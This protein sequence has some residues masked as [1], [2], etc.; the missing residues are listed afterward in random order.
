MPT[1][2][3]GLIANIGFYLNLFGWGYIVVNLK[4]A[5]KPDA[6]PGSL[7]IVGAAFLICVGG[8]LTFFS[9]PVSLYL[10]PIIGLLGAAKYMVDEADLVK[11]L[12]KIPLL[13]WITFA[14]ILLRVGFSTSGALNAHDDY[15]GY[16]VLPQRILQT[17]TITP[18][19]FNERRMGV[20]GGAAYLQ[21][22]YLC[23]VPLDSITGLDKGVGIL[24]I[25]GALLSISPNILFNKKGAAIL[26]LCAI[27][28]FNS[29]NITFV[30]ISEAILLLL[31]SEILS[32]DDK[33]RSLFGIAILSASSIAIKNYMVVP[34]VALL[35]LFWLKSL[36]PERKSGSYK[37]VHCLLLTLVLLCPW[38]VLSL[39]SCGTLLFP[40]TGIGNHGSRYGLLEI[41]N[42]AQTPLAK[43][44][45]Y[46]WKF[47]KMPECLICCLGLFLLRHSGKD[48]EAMFA[49]LGIIALLST[50][51]LIVYKSMFLFRYAE[52]I[53]GVGAILTVLWCFKNGKLRSLAACIL[54]LFV[55]KSD[56]IPN[57]Y[58][59]WCD[60]DYRRDFFATMQSS[61]LKM[62]A[63]IPRDAPM[64]VF[65]SHPFLLDFSRN[66]V[67]V[68]DHYGGA[69]PPPGLPLN[70][71]QS[72]KKYLLTQGIQ[73]L[74]F[75]YRDHANYG[76]NN[77]SSRLVSDGSP[78]GER[79]KRLALLNFN[80]QD[81]ILRLS[82]T[83][84]IIFDDGST[85]VIHLAG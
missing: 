2:A 24:L 72:L 30:Y 1:L 18:D 27:L 5:S 56:R 45:E 44:V 63:S 64:A 26:L 57:N 15:H 65:V 79:V 51:W 61:M 52:S 11:V 55:L 50:A 58:K 14:V 70:K 41:A 46:F 42:N 71:E 60:L 34:V 82:K 25:A 19:I 47:L 69:S 12:K 43:H 22:L 6:H 74:V 36:Y 53:I 85:F 9:S 21:S 84:K 40:L 54:I 80:L 76:R 13:V 75:S 49:R 7:A 68:F 33:H 20:L 29:A 77:Y 28:D 16:L 62:Q 32:Q 39:K 31:A 78:Y 8:F 73:Y 23:F 83:E 10:I 59:S 4:G 66:P 17:G 37:A 67:N 3:T 81:M 38:L 35:F 48:R